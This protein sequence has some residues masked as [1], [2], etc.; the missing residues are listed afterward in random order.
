MKNAASWISKNQI[1]L[2]KYKNQYVAITDRIIAFGDH[3]EEVNQKAQTQSEEYVLYYV[4]NYLQQV[5]ICIW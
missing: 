4:P 5:K 2:S 3:L 1:L